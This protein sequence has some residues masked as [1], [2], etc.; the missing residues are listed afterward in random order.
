[1]A[2]E[3]I[4]RLSAE[5]RDCLVAYLDGELEED[6]SREIERKLSASPTARHDV[7]MLSRTWDLLNALPRAKLT[8]E[9]T[10]KTMTLAV[11]QEQVPDLK[12]VNWYPAARRGVVATGWVVILTLAGWVGF[13]ITN[14]WIPNETEM[15][16]RDWEVIENL[17]QYM[18]LGSVQFL[19]ELQK[20]RTFADAPS[21][22]AP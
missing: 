2:A 19:E 8:Q 11:R 20:S 13:Q 15:V 9:F 16:A 4:P 7:E 5:E 10:Q 18:D 14:Q 1:M 17:D 22:P 3:K 6:L 12:S 21:E